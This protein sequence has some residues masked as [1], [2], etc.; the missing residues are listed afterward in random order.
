[1]ITTNNSIKDKKPS[2][3]M[4]LPMGILE[5]FPCVK[6][7]DYITRDLAVSSV[8]GLHKIVHQP[9]TLQE[10]KDPTTRND[11]PTVIRNL[12]AAEAGGPI[13]T[14]NVPQI[15]SFHP[16]RFYQ[17]LKKSMAD[18]KSCGT[19]EGTNG[20]NQSISLAHLSKRP[21]GY[22]E[23]TKG[24]GFCTEFTQRES[25]RASQRIATLAIRVSS[26]FDLTVEKWISMIE[27]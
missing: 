9:S 11:L 17:N 10:T 27:E 15:N 7:V 5:T 14:H 16:P 6:D 12:C 22:G 4:L 18:I 19:L 20:S 24:R 23:S 3:L 13:I 1:M 21:R 2:R 26:I 25:T 8:P